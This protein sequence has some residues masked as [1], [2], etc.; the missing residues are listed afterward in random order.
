MYIVLFVRSAIEREILLALEN[1]SQQQERNHKALLAMFAFIKGEAEIRPSA[2]LDLDL[3]L[4][5]RELFID[6]CNKVESDK[7]TKDA[8]VCLYCTFSSYCSNP[9]THVKNNLVVTICALL[10]LHN[11]LCEEGHPCAM[12]CGASLARW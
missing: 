8:L 12:P 10:R 3:P 7:A 1:I 5:S 6:L 11:W 2:V 9:L 4:T